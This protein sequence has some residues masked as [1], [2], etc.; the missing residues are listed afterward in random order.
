MSE[1][2][3][4]NLFLSATALLVTPGL[5]DNILEGITRRCIMELA[6]RELGL[7]TIERTVARSELYVAEEIFLSGTGAQISSRHQC[8]SKS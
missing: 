2:S 8:G 1:G 7:K 3:A 4:E 6:E 5:S